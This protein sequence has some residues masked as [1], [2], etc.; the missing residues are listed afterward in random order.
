MTSGHLLWVAIGHKHIT[1]DVVSPWFAFVLVQTVSS[2]THSHET[3]QLLDDG[4]I[5][6]EGNNQCVFSF[7]EWR[8]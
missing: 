5:D 4:M 6:S 2:L 7:C 3:V 1:M 8:W